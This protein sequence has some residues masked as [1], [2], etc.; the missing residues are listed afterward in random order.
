MRA[1]VRRRRPGRRQRR[2]C[3]AARLE[4]GKGTEI[5]SGM[6]RCQALGRHRPAPL[7]VPHSRNNRFGKSELET[8]T[9]F[10]RRP[11]S[12]RLL[13]P[14]RPPG[15]AVVAAMQYAAKLFQGLKLSNKPHTKQWHSSEQ[16][17]DHSAIS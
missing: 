17:H 9:R 11:A 4:P 16:L 12:S 5:K 3:R 14:A 15:S 8:T 13:P 7:V 6:W 2:R 10:S 1:P